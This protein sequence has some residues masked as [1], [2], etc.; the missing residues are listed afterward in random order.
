MSP[1]HFLIMHS[2]PLPKKLNDFIFLFQEL[3][4]RAENA[5]LSFKNARCALDD[6][7]LTALVGGAVTTCRRHRRLLLAG[8][9]RVKT[10]SILV[11]FTG[12]PRPRAGKGLVEVLGGAEREVHFPC[13]PAEGRA[14]G[15]CVPHNSRFEAGGRAAGGKGGGPQGREGCVRPP[16]PSL[17]PS[18][19][20]PHAAGARTG[21]PSHL[22]VPSRGRAA[23]SR[24]EPRAHHVGRA[25]QQVS[26]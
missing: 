11:L 10:K 3:K 2:P 18:V 8:T 12:K 23:L 17:R 9:P 15:S 24:R 5:R 14:A 20:P 4:M 19:L 6:S 26:R 1:W 21:R 25:Q 7:N 13:P 16:A 22:L